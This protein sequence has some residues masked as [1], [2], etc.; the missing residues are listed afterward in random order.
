MPFARLNRKMLTPGLSTGGLQSV[1]SAAFRLGG[2]GHPV[3]HDRV[4]DLQPLSRQRFERLAVRH[5]PFSAPGVVVAPSSLCPGKVV[6]R[7]YEQVLQPLL[8]WR[9]AVTEEIEVPAWQLRGAR[10]QYDARLSWLDSSCLICF[11]N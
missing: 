3:P 11:V 6:A 9:D 5:A 4:G 2:L 8:P 10:P 1:R 7:E